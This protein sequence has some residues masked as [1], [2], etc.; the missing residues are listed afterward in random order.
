MRLMNLI[1]PNGK[2][3]LID[4]IALRSQPDIELCEGLINQI[5][6]LE[7]NNLG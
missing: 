2:A 3:G 1:Y 4:N 6:I 7:Y 5:D